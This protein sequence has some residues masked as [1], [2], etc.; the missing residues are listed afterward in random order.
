MFRGTVRTIRRLPLTA[1][2]CLLVVTSAGCSG[3]L[4]DGSQPTESDT[5]APTPTTA[6]TSATDTSP[7][8]TAPDEQL[9]PGLTADGVT[10]PL[11]LADA[12]RATVHNHTFV[13]QQRYTRV[14]ETERSYRLDSLHYTN[15]SHWRWNRT[16]EGMGVAL[17][18][19]NGTFVQYANGE[20]VR[21]RLES[22][23]DVRYGV[24]TISARADAP[25]MPPEDAFVDSLYARNLVY[26]LFATEDVTVE[27]GDD[28]AAHVTGTASELTIAGDTVTNVQFT[29]TVTEAGLVQSLDASYEQG[30]NSI[31]RML[32]FNRTPTNPV[33]RP[34]WY[35]Q[36]GNSS[37]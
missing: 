22:A 7:A 37:E 31:D 3:L 17:D 2:I 25:P 35:A 33:E 5:T 6:A 20:E 24:R 16:G 10:D 36:A 27:H 23:E 13:S 8:T 15:E 18:V 34:D 28:V 30:E 21:Y 26:T 9:A 11:V 12:H 19:T 4:D 29:A 14:N 1:L 32:T